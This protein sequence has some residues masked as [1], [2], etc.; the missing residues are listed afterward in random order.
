MKNRAKCKLCNDII[1]SCHPQDLQICKCGQICVEGG[2]SMRCSSVDWGN[3]IRV[4]DE[5]NEIIPKI[6]NKN[7]PQ[8]NKDQIGDVND[9]I[10]PS[11]KDLLKMLTEMIVNIEKLPQN[12][13]T[14]PIT[15]YDYASLLI[16]LEAIFRSDNND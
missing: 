4:D 5:G 14:A 9:M 7:D 12:A 15:H 6:V 8:A 10:H 3:F 13:M 11:K 1:E 16:L 2:D